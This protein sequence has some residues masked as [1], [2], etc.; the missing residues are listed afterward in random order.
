MYLFTGATPQRDGDMD[1]GIIIHELVMA[2]R[3]G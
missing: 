2:F 3:T 1:N